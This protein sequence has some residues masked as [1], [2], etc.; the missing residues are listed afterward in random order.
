MKELAAELGPLM[1]RGALGVSRLGLLLAYWEKRGEL[2]P[3]PRDERGHRRFVP[4]DLEAIRA[5]VTRWHAEDTVRAEKYRAKPEAERERAQ[6]QMAKRR[7]IVRRHA[8]PF[9]A[10]DADVCAPYTPTAVARRAAVSASVMAKM[11]AE[12]P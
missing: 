4:A 10:C 7:H 2:G 12:Q 8:G 6:T 11:L 5:R 1:V 9:E 3:Y